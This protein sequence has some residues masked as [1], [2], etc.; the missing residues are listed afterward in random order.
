[1]KNNTHIRQGIGNLIKGA[2][3][4]LWGTVKWIWK[5]TVGE[6]ILT[7]APVAA[8]YA[9][10]TYSIPLQYKVAGAIGYIAGFF[11]LGL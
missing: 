6:I 11:K 1:M 3:L 10:F 2:W 5:R 9:Y 8:I 4:I 7:T